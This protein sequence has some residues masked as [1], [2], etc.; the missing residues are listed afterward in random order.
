LRQTVGVVPSGARMHCA[1]CTNFRI[2]ETLAKDARVQVTGRAQGQ[3]W[4]RVRLADNS[5]GC[6][7]ARL[8]Q[9]V[10]PSIAQ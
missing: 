4:Y 9:P 2:I 5:I 10:S 6:V 1:R 3:N 7:W 8:L